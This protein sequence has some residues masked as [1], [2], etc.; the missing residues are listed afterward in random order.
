LHKNTDDEYSPTRKYIW[1]RRNYYRGSGHKWSK[2]IAEKI[3]KGSTNFHL[4]HQ[5]KL[6]LALLYALFVKLFKTDHMLK[7]AYIPD[8]SR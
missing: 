4:Y 7:E 2:L 5:H 3:A 8:H 6:T 1:N